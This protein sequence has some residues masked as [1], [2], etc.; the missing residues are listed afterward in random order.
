MVNH[1]H[2]PATIVNRRDSPHSNFDRY[3][4][5]VPKL[6]SQSRVTA[7]RPTSG[8]CA[9]PTGR[10]ATSPSPVTGRRLTTKWANYLRTHHSQL[11]PT[12]TLTSPLRSSHELLRQGDLGIPMP[13]D[14]RG[15][16]LL[17]ANVPARDAPDFSRPTGSRSQRYLCRASYGREEVHRS[18]QCAI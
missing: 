2:C 8:R 4:G 3:L 12:D 17:L 15:R 9:T 5:S 14:Q 18:R 1:D 13:S 10:C 11:L 6:V 7:G 16:H